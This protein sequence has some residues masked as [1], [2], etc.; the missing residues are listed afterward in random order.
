MKCIDLTRRNALLAGMG[1]GLGALGARPADAVT[2]TN[3]VVVGKEGWLFLVYDDPRQ[4]QTARIGQVTRIMNDAVALFRAR[5][6][7]CAVLLTPAKARIYADFLPDDWRFNAE[8][9]RRYALAVQQLRTSSA[10]VPDVLQL[11]LA[12][13]RSTPNE[14]LFFR[15]D[16]HWT[17]IGAELAATDLAAQIAQRMQFPASRARGTELL[18]RAQIPGSENDLLNLLPGPER[19]KYQQ[20]AFLIRKPAPVRGRNALVEDDDADVVVVGNSFAQPKY[21]LGPMLSNR[22][23]RPVALHWEVHLTGPYRT[24]L[25]AVKG[26][27][28]R[29]QKPKLLVW[30]IIEQDLSLLP[31]DGRAFPNNALSVDEFL[32]GIRQALA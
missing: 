27:N 29:K 30:N 32:S 11:F 28:F 8:S 23:N 3:G 31:S 19:S 24:L 22:L 14:A 18:E 21:N 26:N 12:H 17:P 13:R 10:I 5:G 2:I 16:T 25:N 15:N 4:A 9:E 20:E 1:L 6:I 7:E